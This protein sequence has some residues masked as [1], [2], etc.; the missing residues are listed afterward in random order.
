MVNTFEHLTGFYFSLSFEGESIA[1]KEVS[2]INKEP[3]IEEV[4][5][6]GENRF[7]YRLPTTSSYKNLTLKRAIAPTGSKLISWCQST[8][9]AGL[10]VAI[11]TKDVSVSLL[12]NEGK[13]FKKWTFY[14]VHPT[15]Y[16]VSDLKSQEPQILI[17]TLELAYTYFDEE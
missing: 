4:A 7:K 11:Q 3:G 9:N 2:G 12:N 6:G 8:L 13:V 15:K 17:E 1:F 16:D 14:N 10:A 5:S